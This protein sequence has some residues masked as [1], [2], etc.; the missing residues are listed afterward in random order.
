VSAKSAPAR[1]AKGITD[2]RRYPDVMRFSLN[3]YF[4]FLLDVFFAVF[5]AAFAVFF[6]FF[7]FL[8][9]FPSVIP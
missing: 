4:I 3:V 5:F 9:M 7:A 8:A 1:A 6:A 2:L